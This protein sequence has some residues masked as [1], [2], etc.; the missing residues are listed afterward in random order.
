VVNLSAERHV[1]MVSPF[2]GTLILN[3]KH[4][5]PLDHTRDATL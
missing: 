3:G 1:A 4:E 5:L 2:G